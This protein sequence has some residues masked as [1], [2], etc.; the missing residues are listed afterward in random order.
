[1]N[2]GQGMF[3]LGFFISIVLA[4]ILYLS[5]IPTIIRD[6]YKQG[7][8]DFQKGNVEY[9]LIGPNEVHHILKDK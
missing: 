6:A 4:S 7:Q 9:L 1:M 8:L 3:L 2:R 5:F